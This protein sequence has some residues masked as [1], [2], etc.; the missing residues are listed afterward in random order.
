MAIDPDTEL[1][2]HLPDPE[3]WVVLRGEHFRKELIEDE[4][5]LEIYE[6]ADRHLRE[7]GQVATE[8]VLDDE[9]EIEFTDPETAIGDLI[10]RMRER[11]R[12]NYQREALKKIGKQQK[13]D[14][15]KVPK[16]LVAQGK[17]LQEILTRRGEMYGN[18]DFDRLMKG[19]DEDANR[20]KGPSL[21]FQ[22][23][24]DFTYGQRGVTIYLGP[25]KTWK[26]WFMVKA[27]WENIN[28][29][30][31]PWLY[32]LELPAKETEARLMCMVANIPWWKYIR[33]ELTDAEKKFMGEASAVLD[34]TGAY[35]VAKPPRG[36][37]SLDDLVGRAGDAGAG[38]VFIDQLQY[39]E[40]EGKSLGAW[41]EPGKYFE[42]LDRAKDLAETIPICFA[43]QFN[44]STLHADGMPDVKQAKGA[45]A[46]EETATLVLGLWASK[47]MRKSKRMEVGTLAARNGDFC[48]WE[49]EFDL[50]QQCMFAITGV[51][52]DD[53]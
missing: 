20:G 44:R 10:D 38:S 53:G 47:E 16:M 28:E 43:H 32:P 24:D 39:V 5:V 45:S 46:I 27:T 11:Y 49:V 50:S 25:P 15:T 9:F 34:Q 1:L 21:G 41:N 12:R 2:S 29:G 35:K 13:E 14:P 30:N 19:Y 6:W 23:I 17:E 26:S 22:A 36:E 33:G 40:V 7:Q 48:N 42:V 3:A 18:G 31:Y 8:A 51:V 52:E 37:R 4:G